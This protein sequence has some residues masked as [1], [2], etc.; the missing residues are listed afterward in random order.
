MKQNKLRLIALAF[1]LICAILGITGIFLLRNSEGVVQEDASVTDRFRY[2]LNVPDPFNIKSGNVVEVRVLFA[3]Q[4]EDGYQP[5]SMVGFRLIYAGSG[6]IVNNKG[7]S[8]EIIYPASNITGENSWD[9]A[10]NNA[11]KE[12]TG[13]VLEF[14]AASLDTA[15]YESEEFIQLASIYIELPEGQ[16]ITP[17]ELTIDPDIAFIMTK[18]D[19]QNI[20]D[21]E[22][23]LRLQIVQ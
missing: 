2:V 20:Y 19:G 4:S 3:N 13:Y 8:S 7:K 21:G 15:G 12:E 23:N 16:T 22:T 11:R 18:E 5:V 1:V 10:V 17:D 6:I 9:V 14:A